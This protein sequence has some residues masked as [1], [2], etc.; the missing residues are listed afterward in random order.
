[1]KLVLFQTAA[2]PDVLP[3]LLTNR[4]VVSIADAVAPGATPQLT[5]QHMIADF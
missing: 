2:G 1:V 4:G 3:G 5:M